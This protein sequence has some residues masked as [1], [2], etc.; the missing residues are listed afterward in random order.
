MDEPA[1]LYSGME[2]VPNEAADCLEPGGCR[3]VRWWSKATAGTTAN[4]SPLACPGR[5]RKNAGVMM[6]AETLASPLLPPVMRHP[7]PSFPSPLHSTH[8]AFSVP[9]PLRAR[10][11]LPS[12]RSDKNALDF[13]TSHLVSQHHGYERPQRERKRNES[14]RLW[15][16]RGTERLNEVAS[17][18]SPLIPSFRN[19]HHRP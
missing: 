13:P 17:W 7:L 10:P 16:D 9:V 5:C 19:R 11:P 14:A 3:C 4:R 15:L 8:A 1:A 12:T 6:A 2:L 18:M